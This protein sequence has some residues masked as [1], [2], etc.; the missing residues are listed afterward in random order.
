[1]FKEGSIG[2]SKGSINTTP[3]STF[4]AGTKQSPGMVNKILALQSL[5]HII[6]NLE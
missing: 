2:D 4:G 1:M 6:D 3:V 5:W